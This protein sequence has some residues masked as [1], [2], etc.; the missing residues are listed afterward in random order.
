MAQHKSAI[1]AYKQSLKRRDN[2]TSILTSIR[3]FIKKVE[4]CI[5]N[6]SIEQATAAAKKAESQIMKSVSKGV[7]KKN[8]AARKVSSIAKRVKQLSNKSK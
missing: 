2:N 7:L 4:Q 8:T 5:L 3:T 1:K 6:G